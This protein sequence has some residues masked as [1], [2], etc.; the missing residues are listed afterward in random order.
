MLNLNLFYLEHKN[1]MFPDQGSTQNIIYMSYKFVKGISKH[2][3]FIQST[4]QSKVHN[5]IYSTREVM[6]TVMVY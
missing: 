4:D 3:V 1:G 2:P 6:E 5:A